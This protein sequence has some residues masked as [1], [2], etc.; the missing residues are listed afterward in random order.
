MLARRRR[1]NSGSEN[2]PPSFR[3]QGP[4]SPPAEQGSRFLRTTPPPPPVQPQFD[5]EMTCRDRS[6][7]F[8]SAVKLLQSRQVSIFFIH[9]TTVSKILS[10][11]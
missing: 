7:E 2:S 1:N 9:L 4:Y 11:S 3:S 5:P 6:N 10:V 8:M